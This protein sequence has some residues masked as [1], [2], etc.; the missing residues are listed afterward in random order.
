MVLPSVKDEEIPKLFPKGVDTVKMPSGIN[1]VR[2]TFDY[3][4]MWENM[5]RKK[6]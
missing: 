1:Y 6:F 3:Y 2:T 4:K 5:Q